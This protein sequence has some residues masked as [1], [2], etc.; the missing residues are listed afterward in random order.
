MYLAMVVF[1]CMG[2]TDYLYTKWMQCVTAHNRIGAGIYAALLIFMTSIVTKSYVENM[3]MV[4]P[5]MLGA[6][7]GTVAA[8]RRKG[9]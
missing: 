5:A 9:R 3:Y 8:I 1:I 6:F 7:V 2:I 4:I